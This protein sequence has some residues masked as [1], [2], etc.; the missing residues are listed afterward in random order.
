[1]KTT[2]ANI[3]ERHPALSSVASGIHR[4]LGRRLGRRLSCILSCTLNCRLISRQSRRLSRRL[5]HRLSRRS[6]IISTTIF[7]LFLAQGLY[8]GCNKNSDDK[9][10]AEE[11]YKAWSDAIQKNRC[12]DIYDLLDEKSRWAVMSLVKDT[13]KA[14]ALIKKHYPKNRKQGALARLGPAAGASPQKWMTRHCRQ[15]RLLQKLKPFSGAP[16]KTQKNKDVF[17]VTTPSGEVATLIRDKY[18]RWGCSALKEHLEKVQVR[19]VNI[20]KLTRENVA[21][22]KADSKR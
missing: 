15:N 20:L 12:E 3:T 9:K 10:T 4:G 19:M 13:G 8:S 14:A 7:L 5:G 6:N 21:R 2:K 17:R 1:M 22:F 11:T 16:K 18:G